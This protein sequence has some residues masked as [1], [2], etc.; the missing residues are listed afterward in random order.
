MKQGTLVFGAGGHARAAIDALEACGVPLGG[1]FDDNPE[2]R[3]T[4]CLGHEVAGGREELLAR[5][6][7]GCVVVIAI[8]RNEVRRQLARELEARG[9]RLAGFRHP[10]AVVSRHAVVAET[11]QVLAGAIVNAGARLGEHAVVNTGAIVEHDCRIG[12]FAHVG[13]GATLAGAVEAG[14]GALIGAG[15]TVLPLCRIGAWATVG[16]GAV[17][18]HAVP[19]GTT[20]VGVPARELRGGAAS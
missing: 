19:D 13:P 14:E 8:A 12:A 20:V 18:I 4:S 7:E 10:A 17:V 2:L 5:L 16:A 15:A 6:G 3:G 1:L 9:V 11:A